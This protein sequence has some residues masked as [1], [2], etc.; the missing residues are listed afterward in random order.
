M[1]AAVF[2]YTIGEDNFAPAKFASI[3]N[4]INLILPLAYITAALFILIFGI[5][6]GYTFMTAG[7]N[8]EK[9]QEAKQAL[10]WLLVG[11]V[12]ILSSL[13]IVRVIGMVFGLNLP[14]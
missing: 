12:L 7:D 8:P 11:F 13:L 6:A 2:A 5:R 14:L 1:F 3:A 10:Q 4:F 9:V